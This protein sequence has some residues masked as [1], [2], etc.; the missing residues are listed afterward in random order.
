M[1]SVSVQAPRFDTLPAAVN[2]VTAI[3]LAL[4]CLRDLVRRRRRGA[5]VPWSAWG[6]AIWFVPIGG[7]YI[8]VGQLFLL[9]VLYAPTRQTIGG[10]S[11]DAH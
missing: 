1:G 11:S 5:S 8:P 7:I 4:F 9:A 3:A 2:N 10:Q 6:F